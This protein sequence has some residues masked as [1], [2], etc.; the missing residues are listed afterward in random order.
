MNKD[1][2]KLSRLLLA[3]ACLLTVGSSV[4]ANAA[5]GSVTGYQKIEDAVVGTYRKIEDKFVEKFLE[6]KDET[7]K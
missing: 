5:A 7:E 4:G 3:I 1:K 6:E 2:R